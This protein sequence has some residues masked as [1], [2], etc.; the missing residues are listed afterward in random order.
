MEAKEIIQRLCKL[1]QEVYEQ[2]HQDSSADCFCGEGGYWV[3]S[4]KYDGTHE[5]GYR[6]D[7]HCLEFIEQAVREKLSALGKKVSW[8]RIMTK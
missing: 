8:N 7:G 2:I 5:G 3:T 4:D 6:N 1:Q